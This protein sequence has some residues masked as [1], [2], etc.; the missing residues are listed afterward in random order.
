MMPRGSTG[1]NRAARPEPD[2]ADRLTI[3]HLKTS[4]NGEG[5]VQLIGIPTVTRLRRR[6]HTAGITHGALLRRG[7]HCS[8]IGSRPSPSPPSSPDA[9][10]TPALKTG[11]PG[12]RSG[13][14]RPS[15]SPRPGRAWSK[16]TLP[17]GGPRRRCRSG[18]P[19]ADTPTAAPWPSTATAPDNDNAPQA[20][21]QTPHLPAGFPCA[22][23]EP[24][25]YRP[26]SRTDR[27]A[28]LPLPDRTPARLRTSRTAIH[29]G[30][31]CPMPSGRTLAVRCPKIPGALCPDPAARDDADGRGRG[32]GRPRR[33]PREQHPRA[34]RARLPPSQRPASTTSRTDSTAHRW[35]SA[36]ASTTDRRLQRRTCPFAWRLTRLQRPVSFV[37]IH[38]PVR[39]Q[40]ARL[41]QP[42]L[43]AS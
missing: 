32:Y 42:S 22:L 38:P 13:S 14:A 41:G 1:R 2:G 26:G 5:A 15:P 29:P 30:A 24:S 4:P 19:A 27:G 21:R 36:Q 12:T 6:L 11:S 10:E 40:Q 43:R 16:C 35:R 23:R 3:R 18:T 25:G 39:L 20:A 33:G 28:H 17:D 34:D 37:I 31:E 9:P 7:G 8:P